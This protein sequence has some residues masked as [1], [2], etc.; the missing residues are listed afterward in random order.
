MGTPAPAGTGDSEVLDSEDDEVDGWTRG[1]LDLEE[2]PA[3]LHYFFARSGVR[4]FLDT[5]KSA[6]RDKSDRLPPICTKQLADKVQNMCRRHF[7]R[8]PLIPEVRYTEPR[9][10][11]DGDNPPIDIC[12]V[13]ADNIHEFSVIEM[14][15]LCKKENNP[16]LFRYLWT[17]WYR[18]DSPRY[19]ERWGLISISSCPW[20]PRARTTMRVE[21]HW[22]DIKR[23]YLYLFHRPRLDLL[24]F[25]ITTAFLL[26]RFERWEQACDVRDIPRWYVDFLREWRK[27]YYIGA[28]KLQETILRGRIYGTSLQN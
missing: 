15:N 5:V 3:Y 7:L 26:S 16:R 2:I 22:R 19:Q 13:T 11:Q 27:V 6:V 21:S 8:H 12:K 18:R 23:N 25:I 28:S 9:H 17:N 14:Y 10:L 24:I 4:V 1:Q 20:I